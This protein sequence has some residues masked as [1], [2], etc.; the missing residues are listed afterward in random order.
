MLFEIDVVDA[1]CKL[2]ECS[3][4]EIVQRLDTK[5]HG[6]DIVA[7]K[8]TR[9]YRELRIEAKG[10]TSSRMGSERYGQLF[11]S[12]QVGIHVAEAFYRAAAM[13]SNENKEIDLKV[14][15]AFP[16]NLYHRR[17]VEKINPIVFKLGIAVFWVNEHHQVSVDSTWEL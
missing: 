6:D 3:G 16:D 4:Y 13:L 8:Q 11:D 1:V 2:L 12:T 10:A 14:G 5:Q 7:K 15:M 9:A 17:A